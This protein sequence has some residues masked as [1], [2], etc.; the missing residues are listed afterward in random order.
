MCL[1][2][3]KLAGEYFNINSCPSGWWEELLGL[4]AEIIWLLLAGYILLS[5]GLMEQT[6]SNLVS[7]LQTRPARKSLDLS[8]VYCIVYCTVLCIVLYWALL[9]WYV[10]V[11]PDLIIR[12]Q[13]I[14]MKTNRDSLAVSPL[15][16]VISISVTHDINLYMQNTFSW[17]TSNTH[18]NIGHTVIV[19]LCTVLRKAGEYED[20][21][22]RISSVYFEI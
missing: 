5:T 7:S 11:R 6:I 8:R 3:L 12:I 22:L 10:P 17:M 20:K 13:T 18:T 15:Y 16:L 1:L 4:P 2:Q 21:P 14:L 9:Q 19:Y